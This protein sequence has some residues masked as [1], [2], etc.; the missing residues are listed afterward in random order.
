MS[1]E[2]PAC[3]SGRNSSAKPGLKP[4]AVIAATAARVNVVVADIGEVLVFFFV[5]VLGSVTLNQ[6]RAA[7]RGGYVTNL[8]QLTRG[9]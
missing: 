4:E 8:E 9:L 1:E 6:S 7:V 5:A 2:K 3:G